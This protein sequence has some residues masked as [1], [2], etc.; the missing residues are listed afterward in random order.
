MESKK[1]LLNKIFFDPSGYQSQQQ[2][3][4]DARKLNHSITMREVKDWYS[5]NVERTRYFGGKNS[6]IAPHA[7]YEYQ[8]DLFFVSDLENQK[9]R[10]GMAC[11]DI[12]HKFAT[13]VPIA[14]KQSTDFS[15]GLM[16]RL[17]K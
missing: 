9:F 4:K 17:T 7:N 8:I 1:E 16:E 15:V 5:Q 13:V 14:T 12:F 2:L 11:L 10:I 6:F 3:Y